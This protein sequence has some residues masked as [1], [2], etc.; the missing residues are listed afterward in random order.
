MRNDN[1]FT[2]GAFLVSLPPMSSS[3]RSYGDLPPEGY[4]RNF[5]AVIEAVIEAGDRETE[6]RLSDDERRIRRRGRSSLTHRYDRDNDGLD[7]GEGFDVEDAFGIPLM[8]SQQDETPIDPDVPRSP[9]RSPGPARSSLVAMS[10][11]E[12]RRWEAENNRMSALELQNRAKERRR[13]QRMGRAGTGNG[14]LIPLP[15][16]SED[17]EELNESFRNEPHL[18]SRAMIAPVD[19]AYGTEEYHRIMRSRWTMYRRNEARNREIQQRAIEN[20]L[21]RGFRPYDYDGPTRGY[22]D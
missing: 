21:P 7:I 13:A 22:Y 9:V 8:E 19:A 10:H 17:D 5:D 2:V 11:E 16:Y 20:R 1:H 3:S 4:D 18:M 15:I 12:F 14:R 6:A